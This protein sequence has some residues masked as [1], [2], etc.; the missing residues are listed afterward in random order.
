MRHCC[1]RLSDLLRHRLV[2]LGIATLALTLAWG[3]IFAP[4]ARGFLQDSPPPTP[5]YTPALPT[6]TPTFTPVSAPATDTPVASPTNT[7]AAPPTA[8]FTP[9]G[10]VPTLSPEP[11]RTPLPSG[12]TPTLAAPPP[13]LQLTPPAIVS[14]TVT[15]SEPISVTV[16]PGP[17]DNLVNLIDTF[18]LYSA[19]FL[20]GL[21]FILFLVL[22]VFLYYLYRRS[23]E[24]G[25]GQEPP[26]E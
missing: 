26:P 24:L 21:G 18:V 2:W 4:N 19:Y 6:P 20:L 10:P 11:S 15:P 17:S 16:T 12:P 5:T 13:P 22:I 7:L 23:Q 3:G 25:Q 8:T 14:P 1:G 9:E